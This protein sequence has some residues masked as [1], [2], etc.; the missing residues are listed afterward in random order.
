MVFIMVSHNSNGFQLS[1]KRNELKRPL[2]IINDYIYN[3][4]KRSKRGVHITVH[5]VN[6]RMRRSVGEDSEEAAKIRSLI[7]RGMTMDKNEKMNERSSVPKVKKS[8]TNYLL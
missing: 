6:R 5:G 2:H 8:S 7:F 4:A 1:T 3:M